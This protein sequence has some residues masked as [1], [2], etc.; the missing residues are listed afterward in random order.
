[1]RVK[2]SPAIGVP[3]AAELGTET[4]GVVGGGVPMDSA[5]TDLVRV[6]IDD[7]SNATHGFQKQREKKLGVKESLLC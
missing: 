2:S 7:K 6:F 5:C 4:Y 1:M 3:T